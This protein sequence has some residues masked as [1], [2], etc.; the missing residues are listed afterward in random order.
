MD[1]MGAWAGMIFGLSSGLLIGLVVGTYY[2]LSGDSLINT[3]ARFISVGYFSS[4]VLG[5]ICAFFVRLVIDII[6]V[7]ENTAQK[8]AIRFILAQQEYLP[9]R[10][11]HFLDYAVACVF[12]RKVGDGYIFIHRLLKDYFVS[13]E[14]E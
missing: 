7:I 12:L 2:F 5:I 10:A 9:F 1:F 11:N 14:I 6:L 3:W 13:F 8:L 4:L